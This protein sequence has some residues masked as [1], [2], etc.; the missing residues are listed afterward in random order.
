M[1]S[2]LTFAAAALAVAALFAPAAYAAGLAGT[3]NVTTE[4][5][6]G[7]RKS[8]LTV[9]EADGKLSGHIKGERGE[10]PID[11]IEVDGDSFS[12]VIQ[13][14]T[15]IGTIDLDYTGKLSGD[16]IKGEIETPMGSVQFSGARA[17]E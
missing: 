7:P 14:D 13:M 16:A 6:A 10:G 12:F 3:W 2:K 11:A 9:N 8:V 4:S 17:T 15:A 5:A 1:R